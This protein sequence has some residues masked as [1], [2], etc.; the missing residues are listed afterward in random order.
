[1]SRQAQSP[2]LEIRPAVPGD[3]ATVSALLLAAFEPFRVQ[4]T[5]GGFADTTASVDVVRERLENAKVWLAFLGNEA[6]GTV[7]AIP[8]GE[9]IYIRSMAVT[10]VA[11]GR[12]IGQRL[13][14][15]LEHDA[16]ER[17]FKK[18]YLYTTFVLPAAQPLY[19]KNGFRVTRETPPEEW[20]DMP[21]VEM[22]KVL[23]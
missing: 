12:G 3:E 8:E 23:K 9:K 19:E 4:Y 13:L 6:V 7:T 11:Q 14:K 18:L 22:E 21:G 10:P 1:M 20:H 17:G 16:R 5:A 2:Q 15:T